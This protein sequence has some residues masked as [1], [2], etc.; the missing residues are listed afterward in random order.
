MAGKNLKKVKDTHIRDF[1]STAEYLMEAGKLLLSTLDY[2]DTL[3]NIADLMVPYLADWCAINV[4]DESGSLEE[5]ALVHSEKQNIELLN[6]LRK[7]YP[8]TNQDGGT[9]QVMKTKKGIF[10]PDIKDEMLKSAAKDKKHYEM[11]LKLN[12]GS[13]M[14]LPIIVDNESIGAISF[15][16]EAPVQYTDEDYELAQVFATKA[17]Q[18]IRNA[19]LYKQAKDEIDERKRIEDEL[20]R[21]NTQLEIILQ[22]IADG[23]TVQNTQGKIV[24]A[25]DVAAR[26]CGFSDAQEMVNADTIELSSKIKRFEIYDES[27]KP[28]TISDLPGRKVIQGAEKTEKILRYFDTKTKQEFWT[29]VKARPI[30]DTSNN[31]LYAVNVMTDIT[32]NKVEEK[33]KDE[34]ISIASHELKTPLTSVK[35][36]T[37]LL[38]KHFSKTKD[39]KAK[40]YLR[41]INNQVDRLN[42]LVEDLLD[43][44]KIQLGKLELNKQPIKLYEIVDETIS[45]IKTL[46]EDYDIRVEGNTN[47]MVECDKYRIG[48]VLNNLVNNAIKYSRTNKDI[49]VKITQSKNNNKTIISVIDHGIGISPEHQKLLFQ[50][51]YRVEGQDQSTY[52]GLGIGLYISYEILKR[53]NED[54]W[55]ES[56]QGEGSTFSFTLTNA[57]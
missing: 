39:L 13:V 56:V 41:R 17:A 26:L 51:F 45:D 50:K 1:H 15:A 9:Y 14:I 19:K 57:N 33:R 5:I 22:S 11:I 18:A 27:G 23:I 32:K 8:D 31:V 46:S 44:S 49:I 48:Q 53:H 3:Q 37:Q 34:F 36:F 38:E 28:V 43:V 24:F 2:K 25:N 6:K 4:L 16:R 55:V 10:F 29:I 54:I 40:N 12:L 7:M 30:R 52:A 47:I 42:H 35:A 20:K 21:S